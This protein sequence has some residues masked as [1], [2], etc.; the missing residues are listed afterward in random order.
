MTGSVGKTTFKE[1]IFH[2]LNNNNILVSLLIDGS[3]NHEYFSHKYNIPNE[4]KEHLDFCGKYFKEIQSNKN[5]FKK[6]LN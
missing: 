6:D 1:N 2:I 3:N 4:T 5:F